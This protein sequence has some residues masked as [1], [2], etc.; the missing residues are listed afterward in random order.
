MAHFTVEYTHNI[1]ADADLPRLFADA[2]RLL[3]DT[4]VFPVA[5]LRSR[6]LRLDTWRV[7]DGA[8][9]Y[10]FVHATFRM[11][12]GRDAATRRRVAEAMFALIRA[13]FAPLQ[14]RRL[15]ALSFEL[16][17]LDAELSFKHNNI[18]QR[19]AS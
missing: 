16:T 3:A 2:H 10:A 15:L 18:H 13:H 11:G 14:S 6:A 8:G 17:E 5:G 9:D 1:E 4:G 19:L 12:H 7:A